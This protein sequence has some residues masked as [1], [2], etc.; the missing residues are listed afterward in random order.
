MHSV[1]RGSQPGSDSV[2]WTELLL[3]PNSVQEP[4]GRSLR[5]L[6][7]AQRLDRWADLAEGRSASHV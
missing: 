5:E 3:P 2:T 6:S 4:A 1:S 7:A